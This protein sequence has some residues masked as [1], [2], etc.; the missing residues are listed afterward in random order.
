[1]RL[2]L[3]CR[4]V[5]WLQTPLC[6]AGPVAAAAAAP[7]HTTWHQQHWGPPTNLSNLTSLT[8]QQALPSSSPHQ[9]N[10]GWLLTVHIVSECS[11]Q[12]SQRVAPGTELQQPQRQ[13]HAH[14]WHDQ[15]G[16]VLCLSE[17][18]VEADGEPVVQL[19]HAVLKATVTVAPLHQPEAN[20]EWSHWQA[21]HVLSAAG[22][23]VSTG[24]NRVAPKKTK[25]SCEAKRKKINNPL[26][27]TRSAIRQ[28]PVEFASVLWQYDR[29]V[30]L[31]DLYL[32]PPT[33]GIWM[34]CIIHNCQCANTETR[35]YSSMFLLLLWMSDLRWIQLIICV[36]SMKRCEVAKSEKTQGLNVDG[37]MMKSCSNSL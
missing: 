24:C 2:E 11:L 16:A 20:E 26:G 10:M 18:L 25:K 31:S 21:T 1:M 7:L 19:S 4:Q 13:G 23:E 30:A 27:S 14:R 3:V 32:G 5:L 6:S 36:I 12:L 33:T 34:I 37:S 29:A 8:A 15:V 22:G 28:L 35:H 9:K 17:R